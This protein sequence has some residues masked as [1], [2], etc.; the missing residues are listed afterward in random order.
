MHVQVLELGAMGLRHWRIVGCSAV[1]GSGLL[2]GI[3]WAV[4]DVNGRRFLLD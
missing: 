3:D 4:S 1:T 2:D